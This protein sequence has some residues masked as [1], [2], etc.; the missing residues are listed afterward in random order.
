MPKLLMIGCYKRHIAS[1]H[2]RMFENV[3]DWEHLPHLHS[4]TFSDIKLIKKGKKTIKFLV[5]LWPSKLRLKQTV[6]LQGCKHKRIWIVRIKTGFMKGLLIRSRVSP[7]TPEGFQ[8]KVEFFIPWSKWYYAPLGPFLYLSY[9]R[10][11]SEDVGMMIARQQY[12]DK[13]RTIDK[14]FQKEQI[15]IGHEKGLKTPHLF[16]FQG[17]DYLLNKYNGSW[18][19]YAAHCPHMQRSFKD[20]TVKNGKIYC[21]WHGYE[22]DIETG[23]SKQSSC[24]LPVAPKVIRSGEFLKATL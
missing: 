11:Y 20:L 23:R 21:P 5:S 15:T 2:D 4:Q 13:D 24:Q 19:A 8:V 1:N 7:E 9:R 16:S 17:K 22:F 18:I 10:L 12:L 3:F 6:Q 14:T